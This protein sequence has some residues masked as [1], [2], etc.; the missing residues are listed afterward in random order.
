MTVAHYT[1]TDGRFRKETKRTQ[2]ICKSDKS[3]SVY[4]L[5]FINPGKLSS[6]AGGFDPARFP[7][8]ARFMEVFSSAPPLPSHSQ[9]CRGHV[10][11]GA[12]GWRAETARAP[13]RD[14]PETKT[15][16]RLCAAPSTCPTRAA[17]RLMSCQRRLVV[18]Q[19]SQ[20]AGLTIFFHHHGAVF[21][22]SRGGFEYLC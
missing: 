15:T 6:P 3:L 19:S 5:H 8:D 10:H 2:I 13:I 4:S 14:A 7:E 1:L 17:A 16:T 12:P 20:S 11:G 9:G 18:A 22:F 21:I